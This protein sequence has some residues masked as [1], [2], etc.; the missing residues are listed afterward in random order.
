MPSAIEFVQEQQAEEKKAEEKKAAEE[1]AAKK[2]AA[3]Q[4][5][6]ASSRPSLVPVPSDSIAGLKK[7]H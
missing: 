1:A 3:Q 6:S 7:N 4:Q 2:E 5:P